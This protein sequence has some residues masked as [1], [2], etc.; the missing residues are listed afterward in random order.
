MTITVTDIVAGPFTA[1]GVEQELA[2]DFK[3]FTPAEIEVV[4]G[5]DRLPILPTGYTVES[6]VA[7]DGF[8]IEEGGA[9][10]LLA[11]AVTAGLQVRLIAKP[12]LTQDQVFNDQG[13]RISNMNEA[14]DRAALR[15][16]RAVY[17]ASRISGAS[18]EDV[19]QALATANAAL[20]A[21][22]AATTA[23]GAHVGGGGAAH[24]AATT[25]VAGFMSAA[26]KIKLDAV[27]AGATA[28]A[29]DAALRD[30][31]TH[32]GSQAIS[33]VTGL[34]TALDAR[35]LVSSVGVANGVTPLGP[36]NKVPSSY[37][38]SSGSYKGT[39]NANTNTPTITSGTG[40]NGDFYKVA[41]AGTTTID[42]VSTWAEGDE[43]RFN[44]T[45]WQRVPGSSAVSS[46]AGRTGAVV[47]AKADVGLGNVDNT[48]DLNKPISTATQ[49]AL[50]GKAN[51]AHTHAISDVT[52]LAAGL[53]ALA[54]LAGATFTGDVAFNTRATFA[55]AQTAVEPT[56]ARANDYGQVIAANTRLCV[57]QGTVTTPITD[58]AWAKPMVYFER[59]VAGRMSEPP[60]GLI[61]GNLDSNWLLAPTFMVQTV[62]GANGSNA[63]AGVHSR[64]I[65]DT[66]IG[67]TPTATGSLSQAGME[68]SVNCLCAYIGTVRVNAPTGQKARPA[69]VQ[70][71]ECVWQTGTA[72]DNLCGVE[73]DMINT[74]GGASGPLPSAG[75]NFTA[76]W[77]QSA[78]RGT[79]GSTKK[80]GTTAMYVADAGIAGM[81]WHAAVVM[82]TAIGSYGC[83]FENSSSTDAPTGMFL[84]GR[85]GYGVR[86]VGNFDT[87]FLKQDS[88]CGAFVADLRN[89]LSAAGAGGI[90]ITTSR[91]SDDTSICEFLSPN[92][93]AFYA[94][95]DATNPIRLRAGGA[96]R[97]VTTAN[98][99]GYDA[100]VFI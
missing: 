96:L 80:Y 78:P 1:T 82:R 2:F 33:T 8:T 64:V 14:L 81:G 51:T 21:A 92:G 24:A 48:T 20:S 22:G 36:D 93:L 28:N 65:S 50:N 69:W 6:N 75:N 4:V 90:K 57:T 100:L 59:H 44:G 72:P 18:Q 46:V 35:V 3:V 74:G 68:I 32:T 97:Q 45:V 66:A 10:T 23:L 91:A 87:N 85:W 61:D 38:P 56:L 55:R 54:A 11:G 60:V 13:T 73:L 63:N 7:V 31:A 76:W 99:G 84:S 12:A 79:S 5:D 19:D 77:A 71:W 53:A 98:I 43:V 83:Y 41:V 88:A 26:D 62:I 16:L 42:G 47:L 89:G 27:A 49:T 34:Q 70:N 17:N 25:S 40:A 29:T 15:A 58:E 67:A 9:V 39:W 94:T 95:G 30:R 86:G 37:L 52:G